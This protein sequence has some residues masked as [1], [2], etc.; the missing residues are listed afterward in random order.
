M[1]APVDELALQWRFFGPAR[2]AN[3]G[4]E[5]AGIIAA[6]ACRHAESVIGLQSCEAVRH[7]L[8]ADEIAAANRN[9]IDPHFRGRDVQQALAE[10]APFEPAGAAIGPGRDLVADQRV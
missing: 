3:T 7:L 8:D 5:G 9:R 4:I 6:I 1:V 10:E 2:L